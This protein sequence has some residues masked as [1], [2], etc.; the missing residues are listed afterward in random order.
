MR[1]RVG[2]VKSK[3]QCVQ[4]PTFNVF[5]NVPYMSSM[6]VVYIVGKKNKMSEVA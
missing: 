6:Y 5:L 3:H 2:T 1:Y 4:K